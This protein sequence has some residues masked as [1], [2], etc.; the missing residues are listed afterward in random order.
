MERKYLLVVL[1]MCT[2][3]LPSALLAGCDSEKRAMAPATPEEQVA[4]E[5]E[6]DSEG[7]FADID[8]YVDIDLTKF[9][10]TMVY[11]EVFNM[12]SSPENYLGKT[13]RTKGNYAPQYFEGTDQYYHYVTVDDAASCCQ[14]GLEFILNGE[15][16]YP[17]DYPAEMA[18][19]EVVGVYKS[20]YELGGTFYYLA[21]DEILLL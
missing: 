2:V 18:E 4:L 13:I 21:T 11:A 3:L 10:N 19:I 1:L 14:Q 9:S 16:T 7:Y 12:M 8:V 20:Y 15:Y 5:T 6:A 17:K